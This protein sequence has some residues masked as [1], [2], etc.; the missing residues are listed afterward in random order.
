MHSRHL[1]DGAHP[2]DLPADVHADVLA[3][4]PADDVADS[5]AGLPAHLPTDLPDAVNRTDRAPAAY[6]VVIAGCGPTGAVLAAEL[7]LHGVRVLVLEKDTEP[8]SYVRIVGLHVRS[9]ELMAM[10]GLL[11]RLLAH[12]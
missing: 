1:P 4:V 10:R 12:G 8:A 7:R 3:D 2:A 9:I 11:D 5:H 6:D